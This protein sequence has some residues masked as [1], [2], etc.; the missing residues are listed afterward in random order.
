MFFVSNCDTKGN[1]DI[2]DIKTSSC[3]KGDYLNFKNGVNYVEINDF[4]YELPVDPLN[5]N[6]FPILGIFDNLELLI[7]TKYWFCQRSW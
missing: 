1:V 6:Y 3:N 2:T 7:S 4:A 5:Y